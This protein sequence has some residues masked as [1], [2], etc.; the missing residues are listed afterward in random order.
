MKP[1][2]RNG[3]VGVIDGTV[4]FVKSWEE[5]SSEGQYCPCCSYNISWHDSLEEGKEQEHLG[6]GKGEGKSIWE[7]FLG[8][9]SFKRNWEEIR[10]WITH[11][12]CYLHNWR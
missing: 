5:I 6:E 9:I 8:E 1:R 11:C 12:P 7:K 3:V 10:K 4:S 2:K